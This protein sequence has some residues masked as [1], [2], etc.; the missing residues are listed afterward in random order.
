MYIRYV[1]ALTFVGDEQQ[2]PFLPCSACKREGGMERSL[3]YLTLPIISSHGSH[4]G[5][6]QSRTG[7]NVPSETV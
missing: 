6:H 3:F 7:Y 2:N 4:E 1:M 5:Y